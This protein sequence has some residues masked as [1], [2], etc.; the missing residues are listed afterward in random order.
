[1]ESSGVMNMPR[2]SIIVPVYNVEKYLAKCL[3]SVI[4]SDLSGYEIIVVN[5]GSTD[6]SPI[7][8]AEY[9]VK[10]AP[11]IRL[12]ST[13]NGGLGAARNVG[14]HA[15]RG[16]YLVFL[17]S[18]DC[19]APGAVGEMLEM[20]KGDFDICLYDLI[21]VNE[22]GLEIGRIRGC[23]RLGE[24][25]FEECPELLTESPCA[26]NKIFC[27]AL[28]SENG[29]EF[30]SRVWYE[31]LRTVPKLYPRARRII[32][33][34]KPWYL[35]LQRCGSITNSADAGRNLEI[36][37]AVDDLTDFYRARG[38]Y[39][40]YREQLEYI[41]FHH[42]FLSAATRV[43]IIDAKSQ[44]QDTLLYDYLKKHPDYMNYDFFAGLSFNH[45]LIH[46]LVIHKMRRT[47]HLLILAN[48][49]IK[50]KKL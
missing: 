32:S 49:F 1:M 3:D 31:D 33:T 30:P 36:I 5:D 40:K 16:D 4:C 22:D 29:I 15:A 48:N 47:L 39:E 19:L 12:I 26:C 46:F 38:L 35:Y 13:P 8:A 27:R 44:V 6:S 42:A 21:S 34:G 9:E 18:D 24:F 50:R 43:N 28:F 10:Y 25:S 7:I 11:L 37:D 14:I 23:N 41:A 45:R 20:A 2:L 17:D